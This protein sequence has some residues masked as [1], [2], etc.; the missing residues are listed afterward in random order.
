M[1]YSSGGIAYQ[2]VTGQEAPWCDPHD[3]R[4]QITGGIGKWQ[5][6]KIHF[7]QP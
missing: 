4:K 7:R 2:I 1:L 3:K 5:R 6:V